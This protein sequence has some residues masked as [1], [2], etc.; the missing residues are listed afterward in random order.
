MGIR[1]SGVQSMP[2]WD[3]PSSN[4]LRSAAL[5]A[6]PIE[7]DFEALHLKS[8]GC[9]GWRGIFGGIFKGK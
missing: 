9:F 3:F 4:S 1:H 6:D 7:H 2:G 5:R 8:L